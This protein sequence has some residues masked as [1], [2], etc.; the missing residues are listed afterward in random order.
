MKY[1]RTPW[2]WLLAL[3]MT[4]TIGALATPTASST[5]SSASRLPGSAAE[6]PRL[7]DC[8]R[9]AGRKPTSGI[10]SNGCRYTGR[11]IP[12]GGAY[13][14][15]AHGSNSYPS[16]LEREI[17]RGLGVRRTY[18]TADRVES[19]VRTARQDLAKNRLPWLSFKLPHSWSAMANGAGDAWARGLARRRARRGGA[20]GVAVLHEPEGDGDVQEWRRMQ[21]RLAPIVR[22]TAPNV[23]FTV[24]MT[25]WHQFYGDEEYSLARI[26]PRN[27]K[28]DVAGF[29]IYQ[30]YGVVKDGRTTTDWTDFS[31]YFRQIAAWARKADVAWGLGE[32]GVTGAAVKKRPSA[33]PNTVQLLERFGG[34]AYSYFDTTLNS[35]ADWTLRPGAKRDGFADAASSSPR[36]R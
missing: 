10:L 16:D 9:S 27:T 28:I 12:Y 29:D 19:A 25:G 11:G 14:G 5:P 30:Q 4:L 31:E 26:W 17:G 1:A 36:M 24:I 7:A 8:P 18:Y 21:E 3:A 32:T 22:S 35:I 20:V 6:D 33:I 13:V 34:V 23:A 2:T 15:A